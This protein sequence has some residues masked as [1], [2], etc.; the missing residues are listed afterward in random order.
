MNFIRK[1]FLIVSA[2][3]GAVFGYVFLH[4]FGMVVHAFFHLHKDEGYLHLHWDEILATFVKAFES[5]HLLPALSYVVLSGMI[6]F[7]F[8]KIIIAHRT[9]NE[10]LQ[11]FSR[12]GIN[13]SGIAHDMSSPLASLRACVYSLEKAG[14]L[15][16]MGACEKMAEEAA[17]ISKMIT[18]IRIIVQGGKTIELS[19]T[20]TNLKSFLEDVVSQTDFQHEIKIDS[21]LEEEVSIDKDYF[22]R[23]LWNLIKNADE[24]LEGIA[25]GR[26]EISA[27]GTDNSALICVSDN[28]P[29]IPQKALKHVFELGQIFGKR[30]GS[31]IGLYNCKKITEA[32]GGK[33]WLNSKANKGT[34]AYIK[35]PKNP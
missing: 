5:S 3:L 4:P 28:G 18:D 15:S 21:T 2:F 19:K 14:K 12:I 8:G 35:I 17:R 29:G 31:G 34:K 11:A 9:I 24:A 22:D 16:Q 25:D 1:H 26:I 32:H 20:P 30:G 13:A 27:E 6:G 23:V 10:Q 7:L 33:I